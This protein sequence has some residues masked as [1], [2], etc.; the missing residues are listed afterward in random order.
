MADFQKDAARIRR[1]SSARQSPVRALSI[2]RLWRVRTQSPGR[3]ALYVGQ[4]GLFQ[5]ARYPGTRTRVR[6]APRNLHRSKPAFF[7]ILLALSVANG[8]VA[9][10]PGEGS[11][12]LARA[13]ALSQQSQSGWTKFPQ[14]N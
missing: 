11:V 6:E 5:S 12:C 13:A 2:L 1:D 9:S 8:V 3:R 4:K 7:A 14:L 10:F